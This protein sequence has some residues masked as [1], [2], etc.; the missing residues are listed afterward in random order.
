MGWDRGNTGRTNRGCWERVSLLL[1]GFLTCSSLASLWEGRAQELSSH[2]ARLQPGLVVRDR[3][4]K[5]IHKNFADVGVSSPSILALFLLKLPPSL[6]IFALCYYVDSCRKE[7]W[8]FF[9]M[10][11]CY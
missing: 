7:A 6:S 9:Q 3:E 2:Q 8:I 4:G 5:K 10:K 1:G 11:S